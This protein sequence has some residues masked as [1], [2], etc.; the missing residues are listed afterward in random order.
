MAHWSA[1]V[2]RQS[3]GASYSG[4]LGVH[5]CGVPLGHLVA[6]LFVFSMH[7]LAVKIL[8]SAKFLFKISKI[9]PNMEISFLYFNS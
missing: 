2:Q 1:Y 9:K 5:A 6:Q 8:T 4:R 3:A 7:I